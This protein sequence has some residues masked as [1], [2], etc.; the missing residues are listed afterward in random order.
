[1]VLYQSAQRGVLD[2][3]AG[4]V[5]GHVG[6]AIRVVFFLTRSLPNLFGGSGVPLAETR[7]IGLL[8]WFPA[9]EML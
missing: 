8:A 6:L 7:W 9:Q 4:H 3:Y 1:M 5:V 2:V